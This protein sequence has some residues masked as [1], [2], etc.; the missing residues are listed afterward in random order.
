MYVEMSAYLK[1][2]YGYKGVS[3]FKR[4]LTAKGT[5]PES[6]KLIG[7]FQHALNNYFM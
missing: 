6:L 3:L 5:I 7:Q 1:C 2:T 4:Y